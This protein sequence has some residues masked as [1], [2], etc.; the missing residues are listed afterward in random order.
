[1]LDRRGRIED[2]EVFKAVVNGYT[3]DLSVM[4]DAKGR[5]NIID[6]WSLCFKVLFLIYYRV[7]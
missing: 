5:S 7:I 2:E 1:M 6:I 3:V 4:Q